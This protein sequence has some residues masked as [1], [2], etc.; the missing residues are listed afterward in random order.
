MICLEENNLVL[1][2]LLLDF[3]WAQ[4]LLQTGKACKH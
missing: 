2:Y 1:V 3:S 4:L